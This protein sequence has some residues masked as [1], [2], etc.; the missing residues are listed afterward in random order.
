MLVV[1]PIFCSLSC[2]FLIWIKY[3]P[4]RWLGNCFDSYII[5]YLSDEIFMHAIQVICYKGKLFNHSGLMVHGENGCQKEIYYIFQ[6]LLSVIKYNLYDCEVALFIFP[7]KKSLSKVCL[8]R[9]KMVLKQ[10]YH[11]EYL[12]C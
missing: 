5:L 6:V 1:T 3:F 12:G 11:R 4:Q 8:R 10:M 7:V 9:E 2:A